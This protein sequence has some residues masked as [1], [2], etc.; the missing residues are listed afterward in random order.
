MAASIV[1]EKHM[2]RFRRSPWLAL[3]VLAAIP[4]TAPAD[5]N[6]Q[7][8]AENARQLEQWRTDPALFARLRAEAT[9]FLEMPSER[10]QQLLKLD[11]D[12]HALPRA[13]E[14]RLL[15]VA[16]RYRAWLERLPEADRQIIRETAEPQARLQLIREMRE[17]EWIGRLPAKQRE[18][19]EKAPPD[20]RAQLVLQLRRAGQQRRQFWR[21]HFQHWD[22]L[23]RKQPMPATPAD[24]SAEV[25]TYV[26]EY[27][28]QFLSPDEKTRLTTAEGKWPYYP[29]MLVR[30]ADT[31]PM[32]LPGKSGPTHFM[33]LPVDLQ[34]KLSAKVMDPGQAN[35]K[36]AEG[37]WPDYAMV[38]ANIARRRGIRLSPYELWPS[39]RADL[40]PGMVNFL[41]KKLMPVLNDSEKLQLKNAEAKWPPYPRTIQALAAQH[42]LQVPWQTLPGPRER[43]DSY[44]PGKYRPAPTTG[45]VVEAVK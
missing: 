17:R 9:A 15:G 12:L 19:V 25:Q 16:R 37:K 18:N 30:L 36:K 11:Q 29:Y 34:N 22:E 43:W 44:R 40:S 3:V 20:Q 31:H 28:N 45:A 10:R 14:T 27:L 41:D 7:E 42:R 33:D 26:N 1:R 24:F 38:V 5:L 39:R 21:M 35:M 4:L 6:P 32:A 13:N 2:S 23:V 8:R